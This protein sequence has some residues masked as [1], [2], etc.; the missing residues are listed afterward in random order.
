MISLFRPK[1]DVKFEKS[2]R[3]MSYLIEETTKIHN[4][5]EGMIGFIRESRD[6]LRTLTTA[7]SSSMAGQIDILRK[8]EKFYDLQIKWTEEQQKL[9][10]ERQETEDDRKF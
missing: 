9:E 2:I 3:A 4:L 5:M 8:M 6:S 1:S 7:L 10:R